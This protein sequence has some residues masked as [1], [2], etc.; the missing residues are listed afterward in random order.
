MSEPASPLW[1]K[2]GT[3]HYWGEPLYGYYRSDD[4]WVLRRHAALLADAG[5]DTLIFDTTNAVTYRTTYMK[6]C[7]VFAAVRRAGGRT[8]QIAF[9]V[10]SQARRTAEEIYRDLYKPNSIPSFGSAGKASR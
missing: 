3:A 8:P 1:G 10:N 5:I 4:P 7:E 6:L 2:L 9:M